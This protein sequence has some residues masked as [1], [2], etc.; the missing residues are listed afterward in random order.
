MLAA[1]T[2][3]FALLA[4]ASHVLA[5]PLPNSENETWPSSWDSLDENQ[6]HF[7]AFNFPIQVSAIVFHFQGSLATAI[8]RVSLLLN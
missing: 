5:S 8:W 6:N 1:R 4:L 3:S 2:L 7:N